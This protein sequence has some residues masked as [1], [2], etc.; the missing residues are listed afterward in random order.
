MARDWFDTRMGLTFLISVTYLSRKDDLDLE[1][2]CARLTA[3]W[4][5]GTSFGYESSE[6]LEDF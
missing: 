1:P 6:N 5:P 2:Q 4:P 3:A